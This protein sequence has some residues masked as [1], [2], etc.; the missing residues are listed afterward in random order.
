MKKIVSVFLMIFVAITAAACNPTSFETSSVTSSQAPEAVESTL[1]EFDAAPYGT[2]PSNLGSGGG[3]VTDTDAIYYL[4]YELY[5]VGAVE[6]YRLWKYDFAAKE[7]RQLAEFRTDYLNIYG[8]RIYY[9]NNADKCVYSMNTDGKDIRQLTREAVNK[10]LIYEGKLYCMADAE[11]YTLTPDA[12]DKSVLYSGKCTGIWIDGEKIYIISDGNQ[13]GTLSGGVFTPINGV[14]AYSII[15]NNGWI[16]FLNAG[17]SSRVYKAR[18]DGTD[19]FKL[20]S[21]ISENLMIA[22]GMLYFVSI[23]VEY[24]LVRIDSN[25]ENKVLLSNDRAKNVNIIG[26]N[27]LYTDLR[28]SDLRLLK[29]GRNTATDFLYM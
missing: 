8:G 19:L 4:R 26:E 25:G 27:M 23:D 2:H 28:S 24:A 1:S 12:A 11:L 5:E 18:T 13:V 21:G 20:Y 10:L 6:E 3:A 15:V 14:L 7:H 29:I 22:K 17:D 16:Y 9:I